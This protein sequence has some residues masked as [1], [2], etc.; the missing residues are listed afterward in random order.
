MCGTAAMPTAAEACE[1]RCLRQASQRAEETRNGSRQ[2]VAVQVHFPVA[3]AYTFTV[4]HHHHPCP[5]PA[6]PL[7]ARQSASRGTLGWCH[8]V[9]CLPSTVPC[10]TRNRR[11]WR[12]VHAQPNGA[13]PLTSSQS[14]SR[15]TPGWRHSAGSSPIPGRC[16][17]ITDGHSVACHEQCTHPHRKPVNEPSDCGMAPLSSFSFKFTLLQSITSLSASASPRREHHS[18]RAS[19]RTSSQ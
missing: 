6:S 16:R 5:Q 19:P 12:H 4:A 11:Q 7:T 13:S 3:I 10:T 9:D 8:S 15:G 18:Q 2:L 14:V 1:C 17:T